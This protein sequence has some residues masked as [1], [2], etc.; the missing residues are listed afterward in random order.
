MNQAEKERIEEVRSAFTNLAVA[1]SNIMT[2]TQAVC[3]RMV[4]YLEAMRTDYDM[5][6]FVEQYRTGPFCPKPILY[7]N[8]YRSPAT[9]K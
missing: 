2:V 8:F 6:Y 7:E 4:V 9:G 5:R 1:L 3:D